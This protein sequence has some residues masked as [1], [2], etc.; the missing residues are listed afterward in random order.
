[1]NYLVDV[2]DIVNFFLTENPRRGGVS[3]EGWGRGSEGP[4]GCLQGIWGG[5]VLIFFFFG[6]EIPTVN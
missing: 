6:A 5:G 4:G 2:S 1:M 3:R